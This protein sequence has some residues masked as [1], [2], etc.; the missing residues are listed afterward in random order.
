MKFRRTF[1]AAVLS[2]ALFGAAF[3]LAAQPVPPAQP[4][5]PVVRGLGFLGVGIQEITPERAKDL[6]LHE[7]TGV[8]VTRVRPESPAEASGL[9]A[10]DVILQF[11][12]TKVEGME[13]ISRLVRE[14]PVGKEV[15]VDI[16]R[17]GSPL[18]LTVR[19]G[20]V[21]G[22]PVFSRDGIAPNAP[23]APRVFQ[24]WRSPMLGVEVEAVEGQLAQYFGVKQGVLVRSVIQHSPAE[25]AA[26]KAGDVIVRVDDIPVTTPADVS[27]KLRSLNGKTFGVAIMR[28]HKE[29]PVSVTL[30]AV[31][32]IGAH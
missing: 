30:E 27:G 18:V 24:G 3:P 25:K 4:A 10:G 16:V 15:K 1:P 11:N 31:N 17:S 28:E 29:M 12:G 23:D 6:K 20:Q 2:L 26:I 32:E 13:Q 22:L 7:E 14:T 5:R 9:K 19:I 21:P 8:E